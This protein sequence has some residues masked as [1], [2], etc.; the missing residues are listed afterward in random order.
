ME[1]QDVVMKRR[2]WRNFEASRPLPEGALDSILAN[3][4]HAPSAGFSQGWAFMVF[5]TPAELER[6]FE[7]TWPKESREASW[8]QGIPNASAVIVPL[9][10]KDIYLDR[11]AEPDKGWTDRDE[12]HWPVPFW[13]IDTGFAAMLMLLTIVDLGLGALFYGITAIDAFREAFGV[14]PEYTPIGAIAV[15][16]PLPD[17]RSPSLKRGRRSVEAVMHRGRW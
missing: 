17:E 16:Y 7:V 6:Y 11:Y 3:A 15:G 10:N 4:L 14:P 9:S 8:T 2:M 12:S 1:F 13:H 5:E